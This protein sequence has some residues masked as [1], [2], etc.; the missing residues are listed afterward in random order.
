MTRAAY[1]PGVAAI[2]S[3]RRVL[4]VGAFFVFA[5]VLCLGPIGAAADEMTAVWANSGQDK[6][7]RGIGARSA[8]P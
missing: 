5:G 4:P 1:C 2:D 3:V 7:A 6:V 8:V